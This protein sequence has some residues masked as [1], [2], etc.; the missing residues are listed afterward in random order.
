MK[1]SFKIRTIASTQ[2]FPSLPTR[3]MSSGEVTLSTLI[4]ACYK[5]IREDM[6]GDSVSEHEGGRLVKPSVA[7][8]I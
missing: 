2:W 5:R 6:E 4:Y 7:E 8:N 1:S 3:T